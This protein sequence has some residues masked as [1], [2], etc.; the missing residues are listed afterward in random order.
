MSE[1]SVEE[2]RARF[3]AWAKPKGL[4]LDPWPGTEKDYYRE[5]QTSWDAWKAAYAD[6]REQIERAREGVTDEVVAIAEKAYD[7]EINK[8]N[9]DVSAQ[10]G[11]AS[12]DLSVDYAIRAALQS[13]AHLLPSGERGG[14][15]ED[16]FVQPVPDHCDRIV[17]RGKYYGLAALAQPAQ[18][19]GVD[20][21]RWDNFP[22]WLIDK[23]EGETISEEFLQH[24]VAEMLK[25][26]RY[27][28]TTAEP[29]ALGEAVDEIEDL[30]EDHEWD[31][32]KWVRKDAKP[33]SPEQPAGRQ[34]ES[35]PMTEQ[36]VRQWIDACN[37]RSARQ[38]LRDYLRLRD[39]PAAPVGVPD[40][41]VLV[42][43]AY[44]DAVKKA[45]GI[46]S[47][48]SPCIDAVEASGGDDHDDPSCA[49]HHVLYYAG[50]LLA[51]A[52]PSNSPTTGAIGENGK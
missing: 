22:G 49:I 2:V 19:A 48:Y 24:Q 36:Q 47:A 20:G 33:A 37:S 51:A 31:G 16:T 38:V 13:V 5:T 43:Q 9:T 28:E 4:S 35:F 11:E 44:V 40:G 18:V 41:M 32:Q 10:C 27:N 23:C 46:A 12:R 21:F 52:P 15:D 42:P 29:V 50:F 34:G 14:V 17:W 39:H 26:S 30:G 25:D 3:E 6:L 8:A 7:A 45:A 1:Y